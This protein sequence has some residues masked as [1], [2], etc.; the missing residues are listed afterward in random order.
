[1]KHLTLNY[2]AF[3]AGL[4]LEIWVI[5]KSLRALVTTMLWG[6][7]AS[8]VAF[9]PGRDEQG[10]SLERKLAMW[11]IMLVVTTLIATLIGLRK[12]LL[13]ALHEGAS[14]LLALAYGYWIIEVAQ[15]LRLTLIV[16]AILLLPCAPILFSA[17]TYAELG[18]R[19][20]MALSVIS[21]AMAVAIGV[22]FFKGVME[23]Q[24]AERLLG[25]GEA[26]FALQ[27]LAQHLLMGASFVYVCHQAL[28][29]AHFIPN[30]RG[31]YLTNLNEVMEEHLSRFSPEQLP[32]WV[33]AL[34]TALGGGFLAL[35]YWAQLMPY[36]T[37]ISLMLVVGSALLAVTE[38]A[39]HPRWYAPRE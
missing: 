27:V 10:Y 21:S 8:A 22:S 9:L 17:F 28:L 5:T 33:A 2:C 30:G 31:D 16:Q 15:P 32:V 26:G 1:M 14:L 24:S 4:V 3:F 36:R 6:F 12:Y 34:T 13:T 23:L 7:A 35:N 37:A 18:P 38:R 25:Q 19:F 20:R 29:L 39:F 11:P